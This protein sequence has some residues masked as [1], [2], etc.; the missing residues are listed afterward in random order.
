MT[1]SRGETYRPVTIRVSRDVTIEISAVVPNEG[2]QLGMARLWWVPAEVSEAAGQII[3]NC[4]LP[5][6]RMTI[7]L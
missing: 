5:R 7:S 2:I 3:T 6:R 4:G 1:S